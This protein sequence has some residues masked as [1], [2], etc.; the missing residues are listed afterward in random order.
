IT[1]C[2]RITFLLYGLDL[3]LQRIDLLLD[4]GQLVGKCLRVQVCGGS[5]G[6]G[7]GG[8]GSGGGGRGGGR[9]GGGGG[10]VTRRRVSALGAVSVWRRHGRSSAECAGRRWVCSAGQWGAVP[11]S[12]GRNGRYTTVP[13]ARRT[14]PRDEYSKEPQPRTRAHA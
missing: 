13:Q 5:S 1:L 6:A 10:A 14:R 3:G 8:G 12:P 7:G 2:A 9:G 4:V 11:H